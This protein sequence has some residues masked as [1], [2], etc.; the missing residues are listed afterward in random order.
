MA[1]AGN[2]LNA[3]PARVSSTSSAVQLGAKAAATVSRAEAASEITITRLRPKTSDSALA[4]SMAKA[5][6]WVVSDSDRLAV[7]GA[8]WNSAENTGMIGCT[9]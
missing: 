7:A 6:L 4:T 3:M 1:V 5:R 9:Q 2:P 8:T